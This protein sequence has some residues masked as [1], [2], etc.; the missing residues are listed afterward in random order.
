MNVFQEIRIPVHCIII[1]ACYESIC[2]KFERKKG[3]T[4]VFQL[5]NCPQV[6]LYDW[7]VKYDFLTISVYDLLG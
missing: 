7:T 2:V 1:N 6:H 3:M 5:S 4:L